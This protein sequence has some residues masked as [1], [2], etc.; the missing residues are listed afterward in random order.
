MASWNNENQQPASGG[1]PTA[2]PLGGSLRKDDIQLKRLG[3]Q[4][5][6]PVELIKGAFEFIKAHPLETA[7]L[8]IGVIIVFSII[9]QIVSF[10]ANFVAATVGGS[11]GNAIGGDAG[12]A[13]SIGITVVTSL[14]VGVVGQVIMAALMGGINI[15]WLR[16]IRGQSASINDAMAIKS[17]I[18][19]L[20]LTSIM[21][22]FAITFG[23]L[24]LIVPGVVLAL[25]LAMMQYIVI[26]KNLKF[27]D[28]LKAS[29]ELMDGYKMQYFIFGMILMVVNFI[30]MIPCFLGLIIT[31]PI[32]LGASLMFYN[33]IAEPGNAYNNLGN[34]PDVFS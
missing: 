23:F 19:P 6:D 2:N 13:V 21:G 34:A 24:L 25:G 26:D 15:I 5:I 28:A 16:I 29:W 17:F 20:I 22:Q 9:N 14:V 11:L 18:V 31:I 12:Q 10:V 4:A 30:G 32:S 3:P 8:P 7:V 1:R 27:V 33:A